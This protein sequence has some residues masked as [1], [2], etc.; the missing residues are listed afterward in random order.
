MT[1]A[2]TYF[3]TPQEGEAYRV[4]LE[5]VADGWS[6]TVERDGRRWMFPL[7]RGPEDGRAWIGERLRRWAWSDGRLSLDGVLHPLLVETEARH[8]VREVRAAGS[9]GHQ[10]SE[11]RAPMPGLVVAVLVTEDARVETGQSMVVIEAMKME[12]EIVAPASGIV[13]GVS[14]AAGDTVE[15]SALLCRIEPDGGK[16]P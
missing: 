10:T 14:V 16:A 11:V 2:A 13:Q 4:V 12:N 5:A 1:S 3:V 8:R 6:T 9:A 15:K 7:R